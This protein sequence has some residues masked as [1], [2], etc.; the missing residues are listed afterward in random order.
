MNHLSRLKA[1]YRQD[2]KG[3]WNAHI[4]SC[5]HI[6]VYSA[7]DLETAKVILRIITAEEIAQMASVRTNWQIVEERIIHFERNKELL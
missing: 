1:V 2:E 6:A 5:P 4:V 3:L 7:E